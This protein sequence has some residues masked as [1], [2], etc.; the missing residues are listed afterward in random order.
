MVSGR[1]SKENTQ[2][3][4][5]DYSLNPNILKNVPI[6]DMELS[7][8]DI[9]E[10]VSFT[11]KLVNSH[12]SSIKRKNE[13]S[14]RIKLIENRANDPFLYL[15]VVGEFSSGKSTFI[16]AILRQ[17]L[18]KSAP[19]ATTASVTHI[20][21]GSE[22]S[23][24]VNFIDGEVII[25][26]NNIDLKQ[27][28]SSLIP[29][30][31]FE[32]T[33][34]NY[35]LDLLTSEPSI[36]NNIKRITIK[37]PSIYLENNVSIIDTP[38]INAGANYTKEHEKITQNV[39]DTVA[40]AVIV[41]V[42]SNSAMTATLINFLDANVS[43]LLHR[44]IFVITAMDRQYEEER[45]HIVNFVKSELED[46]LNLSNPVILQS[47][48]ISMLS[49]K[50]MDIYLKPS[51]E[52]W[53]NQ[54]EQLE[55]T[56]KQKMIKQRELIIL[57][58]LIRL[59]QEVMTELADDLKDKNTKLESEMSFLE[60]SSIEKIERLLEN[61]YT[62]NEK[63]V[64]NK[65]NLIKKIVSSKQYSFCAL[66]KAEVNT[67]INKS[68]TD[69]LNYE[70]KISPKVKSIVEGE[71]KSFLKDIN[72]EVS[73]L[74]EMCSGIKKDFA[75]QFEASYTNFPFMGVNI[76]IP[77]LS[78][79]SISIPKLSFSSS[80]NYVKAQKNED[81]N[82]ALKGSIGGAAIGFMFGGPVGALVGLALG[83]LG[84]YVTAGD[85]LNDRRNKLC[86]FANDDIDDFFSEY[87]NEIK[88]ELDSILSK[89]LSQFKEA[90]NAH[91]ME[92]GT[93]VNELIYSH[94]MEKNRLKKEIEFINLDILELSARNEKL[95]HLKTSLLLR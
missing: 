2:C 67:I 27:K 52:Y 88:V 54:F 62:T 51:L 26:S 17:R 74:R 38:G 7:R 4:Q 1:I 73:D 10:H 13:F 93:K 41:L 84:G 11:Q 64:E 21:P 32:K 90:V 39:I 18:L 29:E 14:E 37:I 28:L 6:N 78:V 46:K 83:N 34:I 45:D 33:D 76:T 43:H 89:I 70:E 44:C 22:F 25:A 94:K 80:S 77:S 49:A 82:G 23:V 69:I 47:S 50:G 16:N 63:K 35:L 91:I 48:A 75:D 3:V 72:R 92:Y 5:Q 79:S 56:I 57:E 31:S 19:V 40:D 81:S 58:R 95:N 59:L 71:G 30:L 87:A 20:I 55:E 68:G 85:D 61:L 9:L 8:V 36:A 66:A 86:S 65:I 53:Q 15:A 42:P 24:T 60:S 12:I